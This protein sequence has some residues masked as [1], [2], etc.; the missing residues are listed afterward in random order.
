MNT[1]W[2]D[3]RY[4]SRTLWKKPG[5]VAIAVITLALGIGANTAIFSVVNTLILSAPRIVDAENVG[6]IWRSLKPKREDGYVS[7]LDLQDWRAQNRSF[8]AIA[9]YKPNGFVLIHN[10][11]AERIP[12]MRVTANFLSLLK[13]GLMRGRDFREAEERRGA[14][15]VVILS[16]KYWQDRLGGS[17]DAL[18]SQLNLDGTPFTVIGI[19]QP[20]FEFPLAPDNIELL[21]T[22]AGEGG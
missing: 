22:I 13:V 21:T 2:Q 15:R 18:G 3:L 20:D 7:Y 4:A 14:D 8:E 17:E 1:L 16:H 5:F 10:G 11:Q 12:G 9:A 19:L 6:T